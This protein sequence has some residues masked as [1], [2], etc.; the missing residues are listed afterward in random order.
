MVPLYMKPQ[1]YETPISQFPLFFFLFVMATCSVLGQES[2][3]QR[4][5]QKQDYTMWHNMRFP[6]I[7]GDGKWTSYLLDYEQQNDTLIVM[8]IKGKVKYEFNNAHGGQ[9]APCRTPKL[10]AFNDRNK[11]VGVLNLVEGTTIWIKEAQYYKFSLDGN[12]LACY[13]LNPKNSYLK[14]FDIV[15]NKTTIIKGIQNFEFN[16]SR[17]EVAIITKVNDISK[18][19]ILHFEQMR[20]SLIVSQKNS[21]FLFP[22]WN[23]T[24]DGLVF[25]EEE[26]QSQRKLY[27]F[28]N[29]QLPKLKELDNIDLRK[30]GTLEISKEALSFSDDGERIF[31]STH[32]KLDNLKKQDVDTVKVQVWQ[33]SDNLIYPRKR[34][35]EEFEV[36]DKLA[37]WWPNTEGL[38]QI[39]TTE[40]PKV[41]LPGNQ[42]YALTYDPIFYEPQFKESTQTDFY[43][44][45]L[46]TEDSKLFLEKMETTPEY[47][48][49]SPNGKN[50]AYFKDYNW[51]IY[52]VQNN[53]HYNCT[54]AIHFPVFDKNAPSTARITPYG[55]MGWTT[56]DE[57]LIYDEFDIWK[58]NG[59]DKL[60]KRLT[61]GRQNKTCYRKYY[62]LYSG[63][64]PL[65]ISKNKEYNLSQDIIVTTCDSLFNY[66]YSIIKS[67]G[68]VV[69]F[70]TSSG[71]NSALRKAKFAATFIYLNEKYNKVPSLYKMTP[72]GSKLLAVSNKHQADFKIGKTE[73]ISY[74][75]KEGDK[76]HGL[77]HYPDNYKEGKRYPMIVS[78]YEII[79][80]KFQRYNNPSLYNEDGFNIRNFT[81]AGYFVLEPDILIQRGN[82]GI[83]ATDCT[84]SAV[85]TVLEKGIVNKNALGL[86]GHSFGGYETAFVITQ[87][88]LFA[89]AVVGA[90]VFD[91]VS[92]AHLVNPQTGTTGFGDVEDSQWKMEE[93]FY[94]DKR[95]YIL[96]SPIEHA[97]KVTTPTLIWTGNQDVR[98]DWHQSVEMYLGLRRLGAEVEL[99]I[100][101]DEI[102]VL[103]KK[104]NQQDLSERIE[105][106]FAKY[107]NNIN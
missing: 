56:N 51:W 29:K 12:Y 1:N 40:R 78:I 7:S 28:E 75:N 53:K 99:L 33:G 45:D 67:T 102:H 27:Y 68:K 77:L 41:I 100:Y 72:T 61:S 49:I 91:M 89:T 16:P 24:G 46:E 65:G 64:Y 23:N 97:H 18:V 90:G 21:E 104:Q 47:M 79:S 84:L 92:F 71:Y 59:T 66:G 105:R 38:L 13:N 15:N 82:P 25:M 74:N 88:D 37:V 2:Q 63:F 48:S 58:I 80:H 22:K 26:H 69:P 43:I 73:L 95:R 36:K 34:L 31:F 3:Q 8:D 106:W 83:S 52:D 32:K 6:L 9:F 17:K 20:R 70:I 86:I 93:S 57:F 11:G 44:M 5:L 10:F 39:G 60:P 81:A 96:N 19:E 101:E 4:L 107:L 54:E 87:T 42:K 50:I 85:N 98:I 30:L 103:T 76:L 94:D 55:S 35:Y 14:L 62:D